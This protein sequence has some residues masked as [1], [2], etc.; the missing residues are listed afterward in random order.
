MKRIYPILVI[1]ALVIAGCSGMEAPTP[2][3]IIKNPIGPNAVKVG[4][5]KQ[6]VASIY[7]EPNSKRTVSSTD[8]GGEREEWFYHGRMSGLPVGADYLAN[9]LYLY[10]DGDNLTNISKQPIGKEQKTAAD[11]GEANGK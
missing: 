3:D 8:W 11:N 2:K 7:G 6:E 9:D 1:S 4:M 5:S 10:F